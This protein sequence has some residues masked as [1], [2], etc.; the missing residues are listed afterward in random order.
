MSEGGKEEGEDEDAPES[1]ETNV[2]EEEVVA[3]STPTASKAELR[4][5]LIDCIGLESGD[6]DSTDCSV[7]E[8]HGAYIFAISMRTGEVIGELLP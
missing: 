5:E 8:C 4:S 7:T 2:Q 3:Q 1:V 6:D